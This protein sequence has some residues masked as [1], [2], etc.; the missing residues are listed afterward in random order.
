M[1]FSTFNY[2]ETD[3]TRVTFAYLKHL[4]AVGE[5]PKALAE[6]GATNRIEY[7]IE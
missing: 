3:Q 4:W 6:L 1:H 7:R 2:S 5:K